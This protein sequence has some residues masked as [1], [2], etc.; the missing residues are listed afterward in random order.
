VA[1]ADGWGPLSPIRSFTVQGNTICRSPIVFVHGWNGLGL[2][3]PPESGFLQVANALSAS[4]SVFFADIQS[5]ALYTPPIEQNVQKLIE[6]ID[7]AK[8]TTPAQPK[9]IL[10]AHSMGGLISRA[11]I[12]NNSVYRG[13][14]KEL[15]TFGSPHNGVYEAV[16]GYFASPGGLVSYCLLQPAVCEFSTPGMWLF[17]LRYSARNTNV[18]YHTVNGNANSPLSG[19]GKVLEALTPG[20]DDATVSVSSGLGLTGYLD[21]KETE[22]VH[23]SQLGTKDYFKSDAGQSTSYTQCLK[24]VLVDG[25][26]NCG[27][28]STRRPTRGP[29]SSSTSHTPFIYGTLQAG[30]VVTNAMALE[31]GSTLFATS[32]QTGTLAVTLVDP[33]NQVIDPSFAASNPGIVSYEN[34]DTLATYN[35][36]NAIAGMWRVVL[37]GISV[38]PEGSNFNTFA[39]LSES[40]L[41]LS[42]ST[43]R[44]W[45]T[46]GAVEQLLLLCR[47]HQRL[48]M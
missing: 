3:N 4:Y 40:S 12:E 22:E 11:Y 23:A 32:W 29:V 8:A 36:P 41:A 10:I 24:P 48:P 1:N 42:G 47:L 26:Q 16:L 43:D 6:A 7:Q 21:R 39:I 28:Q 20:E 33:N 5:N 45:Y 15:F 18:K 34:S 9:V 14:V 46:P 27:S 38:P 37:Q 35:F 30:Q 25:A 13:D 2:S 17:N 19:L 31:G 44:V